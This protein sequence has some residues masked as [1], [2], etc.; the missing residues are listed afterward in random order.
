MPTS[1]FNPFA[2]LTIAALLLCLP[3]AGQPAGGDVG[4]A[5]AE[6]S[7]GAV[8]E[9]SSAED[10]AT[11]LE[12]MIKIEDELTGLRRGDDESRFVD[13][14]LKLS[15]FKLNDQPTRE[16]CKAHLKRLRELIPFVASTSTFSPISDVLRQIPVEH[17]DLLID[18]MIAGTTLSRWVGYALQDMDLD[19]LR[20]TFVGKIKAGA[21]DIAIEVIVVQGWWDDVRPEI[22][23][24]INN[25]ESAVTIPWFVAATELRDPGLYPRLHEIA[26]RVAGAEDESIRAMASEYIGAL[27]VIEEYDILKTVN[28]CWKR[29]EAR[30][31][32]KQALADKRF[33]RVTAGLGSVGALGCLVDV[34]STETWSRFAPDFDGK[35]RP[36]LKIIDFHGSNAEIKAW[37]EK[38]KKDL[39]FDYTRNKYVVVKPVAEPRT[40]EEG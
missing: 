18:E 35:P 17:A 40:N 6:P 7:N 3:A 1:L 8:P 20:K 36:I 34:L 10:E 13:I 29:F 38:N 9:F 15:E 33:T 14:R 39:I 32:D 5:N 21:D 30:E 2:S 31:M 24:F 26:V 19:A 22:A 12:G 27:A 37:Y 11:F 23:A 16:E 25:P 28:A 4:A